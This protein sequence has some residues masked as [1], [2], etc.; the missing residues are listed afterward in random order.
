[1]K[2]YN[3]IANQMRFTFVF[4]NIVFP[5]MIVA[6]ILNESG[7]NMI[8]GATAFLMVVITINFVY[9]YLLDQWYFTYYNEEYILQK[10]LNKAKKI[11]FEE[12]KY[13]YF[14][15][16][17]VFLSEYEFNLSVIQFNMKVKRQMKKTL[18]N[19]ICI[20]INVYDKIFPKMLL[21]KCNKASKIDLNVKEKIYR[22]MFELD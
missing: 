18:K 11:K 7:I 3:N 16:N 20:V 19:E 10:W 2:K 17:L 15:D 13:I 8:A 21:T 12:I 6:I 9:F 1:M 4:V 14:I 5:V 22:E